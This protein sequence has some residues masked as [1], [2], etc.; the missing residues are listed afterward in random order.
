MK[1]L[2]LIAFLIVFFALTGYV[3]WYEKTSPESTNSEPIRIVD[4]LSINSMHVL[5]AAEKG[6][7]SDQGLNVQTSYTALGKLAMDSLTSGSVDYAGVVDMNVAQTLFNSD[8]IAILTEFSEPKTGI[9]LLARSDHGI[10]S[11]DDLRG[12]KIAVFFGVN[13]HIFIQKYLAENGV[14]LDEVELVNLKPADAAAAFISGSVDAVVTWQ[15]I[16]QNIREK[17]GDRTLLLTEDS[18]N[19]WTYK[20]IL[21][22]KRSYLD[23]NEEQ[24]KKILLAMIAADQF[25]AENPQEAFS[26]LGRHLQLSPELAAEFGSEIE[27]EIRLTPRLLDMIAFELDWLPRHLPQFFGGRQP[28]TTEIRPLVSDALQTVK[29]AAFQLK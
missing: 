14:A 13:I 20:L 10:A 3:F 7:F 1:K 25:I 5:I 4:G 21:V 19:Y 23:D 29:P 9:K 27:Y 28:V 2:P 8:D 24:A 15:P 6:F 16:V 11:A 26:I 12:K 17:I 22:T 18:R